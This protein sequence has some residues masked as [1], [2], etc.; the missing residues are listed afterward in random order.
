MESR[1]F[2]ALNQPNRCCLCGSHASL[3]EECK[4]K[5][6]AISAEFGNSKMVIGLFG[7]GDL[8]LRQAQSPKSKVFHFQSKLC[9]L[10]N[11]ARTQAADR[12]FDRMHADAR[13]LLNAGNDPAAALSEKKYAVGSPAY[14]DIFR[15][16]A[17]IIFC[18][19]AEVGAPRPINMSKFAIG[20]TKRNCI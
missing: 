20:E 1:I 11:G 2:I 3:T 13:S 12:E 15:Y 7:Q 16:F 4:I 10:C 19:L 6:S 9:K 14:L 18:Q 8:G 17:K 5:R